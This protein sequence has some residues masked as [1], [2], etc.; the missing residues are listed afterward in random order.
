MLQSK[1]NKVHLVM[2]GSFSSYFGATSGTGSPAFTGLVRPMTCFGFASRVAIPL[3]RRA[4]SYGS[5]YI[6][7]ILTFIHPAKPRHQHNR[8]RPGGE[9]AESTNGML[10]LSL[11]QWPDRSD[12]IRAV[13]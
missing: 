11:I 10:V 9:H 3:A 5:K 2:G 4:L 12:K 13:G 8:Q 6:L 7:W 1:P